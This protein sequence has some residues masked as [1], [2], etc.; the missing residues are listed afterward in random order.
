[1]TS[2]YEAQ[3][4]APLVRVQVV[5]QSPTGSHRR[6]LRLHSSSSSRESDL[7]VAMSTIR[8]ASVKEA[9]T[10]MSQGRRVLTNVMA[11]QE[12]A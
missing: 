4:G 2:K 6:S 11:V 12:F 3:G 10:A 1:M 5:W 9:K 7:R 8:K